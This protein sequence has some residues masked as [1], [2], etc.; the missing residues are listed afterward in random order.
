MP[1]PSLARRRRW[2]VR[3][4]EWDDAMRERAWWFR[5]AV[6]ALAATTLVL[7]MFGAGAL[8]G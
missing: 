6:A 1:I 3:L 7:L 2:E 5:L 8:S 4:G